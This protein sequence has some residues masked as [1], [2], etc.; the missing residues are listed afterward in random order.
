MY[1][2]GIDY[3]VTIKNTNFAT[4]KEFDKNYVRLKIYN[5]SSIDIQFN[6]TSF[7]GVVNVN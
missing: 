1:T 4:Y 5:E 2:G 6:D 3:T 7:L